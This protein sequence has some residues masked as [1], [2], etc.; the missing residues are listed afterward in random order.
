MNDIAQVGLAPKEPDL[1]EH[2]VV[3]TDELLELFEGY[4]VPKS[5]QE[6]LLRFAY[7]WNAVPMGFRFN[8]GGNN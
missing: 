3:P 2:I 6:I 1:P 8:K 5:T 7:S 4:G